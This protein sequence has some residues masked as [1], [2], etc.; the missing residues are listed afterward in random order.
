M[1]AKPILISM[2]CQMADETLAEGESLHNMQSL[3]YN[4]IFFGRAPQID[5][6]HAEMHFQENLVVQSWCH[7]YCCEEADEKDY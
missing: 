1:Q 6:P 7:H 5:T 2:A 4:W 3:F